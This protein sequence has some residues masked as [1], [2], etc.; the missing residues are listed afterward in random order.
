[1]NRKYSKFLVFL[2]ALCGVCSPLSSLA[3]GQTG[4]EWN[5]NSISSV[6]GNSNSDMNTVY[7]YNVGTKKFLNVG[8]YWGT[9]VSAYNVGMPIKL[10]LQDGNYRMEGPLQTPEGTYLAFGRR[11][12][13]QDTNPVSWNRV[14]CDRGT[15]DPVT[16]VNGIL[17]WT[18]KETPKNSKTYTINC[19]NDEKNEGMY[20]LRY[21]CVNNLTVG[22]NRFELNYLHNVD[23]DLGRWKIVTLKDLKEAFKEQYASDQD[24]ADATFLIEDQDFSRS[25][26][27]VEKWVPD[28]FKWAFYNNNI[29]KTYRFLSGKEYNYYVGMG[30][31]KSDGYQTKYGRYWIGS[32]R[33]LKDLYSSSSAHANGTLTQTVTVLKAGW[34]RVYCDGFYSPGSWRSTLHSSI[35]AKVQGVG[36]GVSNVSAT[37]DIFRNEFPYTESDL[38]YVYEAKDVHTESPYVKA[39]KLFEQGRYKNMILVYV[40]TAGA[41]LDIGIKVEGS[42]QSGDWT[43]FDNFQLQYCGNRDLILDESQTSTH[44]MDLQKDANYAYTLILKRTMSQNKWNSITLPVKLTVGQFKTAF[45]DQAK[46]SVLKGT[47]P[48]RDTRILFESVDLT[49]DYATA[50]QPG[51]LYIM[52]STRGANVTSGSYKKKLSDN[53]EITVQ[54]PYFVINNVSLTSTPAPTFKETSKPS[55]TSDVKLQFC[56]TQVRQTSDFV[57]AYSYVLGATDGKWHYTQTNMP[58]KGFR[59]WVATGDAA[60]AKRMIFAIDGK[61]EGETTDIDMPHAESRPTLTGTIYSIDGRIVKRNATSLEGLPKGIY[62]INNRKYTVK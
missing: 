47:D 22:S 12:D 25:N 44:Y 57:P 26:K 53:T 6:I 2:L 5:G 29:K 15:S 13:T 42:N 40:P 23:N 11:R 10:S 3:Q 43:A 8:S 28:G 35:F 60:T 39:A 32:V 33:N 34:Y 49:N 30:C 16:G 9:S 4:N 19:F 62:I 21:L 37:L 52:Q 61:D 59:C 7:L 56:G 41:K 27:K 58:I 24:P 51:K 36:E 46:L 38:T 18:F 20:G 48:N 50:I 54:A 45:G 14:Y 1:M 17:N 31:V 55:P